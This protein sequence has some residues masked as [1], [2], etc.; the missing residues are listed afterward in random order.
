M[1]FLKLRNTTV[2]EFSSLLSHPLFPLMCPHEYE[3]NYCDLEPQQMEKVTELWKLLNQNR[4]QKT[5]SIAFRGEKKEALR[6]RLFNSSDDNS[7]NSKLARRIFYFG[8]KAKHYFSAEG[9]DRDRLFESINDVSSSAFETIFNELKRIFSAKY[10]NQKVSKAIEDFSIKNPNFIDYFQSIENQGSFFDKA[11]AVEDIELLRNY[12]LYLLHTFGGKRLS[13][14]SLFISTSEDPGLAR[15]FALSDRKESVN[16]RS[17]IYV[18]FFP[19]KVRSHGISISIVQ[20]L[21][22]EYHKTGLPTYST[23][24]YE[25]NEISIKGGLFPQ[26]L[27]GY[28][29]LENYCFVVNPYIFDPSVTVEEIVNNGLKIDQSDFHSRIQETGFQRYLWAIGDDFSE[30]SV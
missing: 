30:Y 24:L 13:K 15:V 28:F 6:Q 14:S 29:D 7:S 12:Y 20:K 21:F 11:I 4:R 5:I 23:D 19:R 1:D 10:S 22:K 2:D 18:C 17:I 3:D 27:F 16:G 26:F 8:D 9:T 25:E